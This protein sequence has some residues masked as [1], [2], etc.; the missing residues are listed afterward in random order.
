[1]LLW[2]GERLDIERQLLE[3]ERQLLEQERQRAE[4]AEAKSTRLAEKLKA[5][6]VNTEEI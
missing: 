3:Q 6:G 5:M 2:G 4:Q 1:L